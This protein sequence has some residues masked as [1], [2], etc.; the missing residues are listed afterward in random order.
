VDVLYILGNGS[1]WDNNELR[2]SLRSLEK[3]GNG[4]NRVFVTGYTPDFLNSNVIY[5]YH[6][7]NYAPNINHLMKVLW[8][9]QNTDISDDILLNYDD[10]FFVKDIEVEE[11]PFYFKRE[12]LPDTFPISNIHTRSLLYTKKIL[13]Q[14]N[15]PTKDF[16]VHCPIIYNRQKFYDFIDVFKEYIKL[17]NRETSISVRCAYLNNIGVVGE[18]LKDLKIIGITSINDIEEKI[19]DRNIFSIGENIQK[20]R[21]IDFLKMNYPNKSKWEI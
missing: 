18:Y 17:D 12:E 7:D 19:K 21:I 20:G 11:Y 15:K 14:L 5:N 9:F 6:S 16:A 4:Y 8:T 2:Y 13:K 1:K 3:H 10:N